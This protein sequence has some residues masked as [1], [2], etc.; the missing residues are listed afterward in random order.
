MEVTTDSQSN[1]YITTT[2]DNCL[3]KFNKDGTHIKTVTGTGHKGGQFSFP[4]GMC[5]F[6]DQFLY[7]CD[8]KNSRVLVFDLSLKYL[9]EV[10]GRFVAPTN[11]AIDTSG[12]I[13]LCD[14]KRGCIQ[15]LFPNGQHVHTITHQLMSIPVTVRIF[16]EVLYVCAANKNCVL[17]FTLLGEYIGSFGKGHLSFPEGIAIDEDGYFYVSN[18]RQS[19]LIL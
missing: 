13:Y 8:S 10:R 7:V 12:K 6:E 9:S 3:H 17:A 19:I 2:E 14:A 16:G 18:Q 1:I 11:I 4:N 15:V 5:I